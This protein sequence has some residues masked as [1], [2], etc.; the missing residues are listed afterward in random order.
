M[1]LFFLSAVTGLTT[2]VTKQEFDKLIKQM[3]FRKFTNHFIKRFR[4][5][6]DSEQWMCGESTLKLLRYNIN[7]QIWNCSTVLCQKVN[8]TS[9]Y[10]SQC[11][12]LVY[13]GETDRP[14]SFPSVVTF[15]VLEWEHI[16]HMFKRNIQSQHFITFLVC[17]EFMF[18]FDLF[19]KLKNFYRLFPSP[20]TTPL[21]LRL[22]IFSMF[23]FIASSK[24]TGLLIRVS[25]HNMQYIWNCKYKIKI[26]FVRKLINSLSGIEKLHICIIKH[27][28]C[29]Q[30]MWNWHI[31]RLQ[32]FLLMLSSDF[33]VFLTLI[34]CTFMS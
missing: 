19:L 10:R 12:F 9:I 31:D 8:N 30:K 11:S 21:F 4:D 18:I 26:V 29:R 13:L 1:G 33:H 24:G 15:L 14:W 17:K 23:F 28:I 16:M 6:L 25:Y 22:W 7:A 34:V 20:L 27:I 32:G 5:N 3:Q 2:F